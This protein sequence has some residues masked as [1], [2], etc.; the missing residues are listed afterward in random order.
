MGFASFMEDYPWIMGIVYI[1]CGPIIALFGKRWFPW[2]V[3][4]FVS[5]FTFLAVLMLF[6]VFGWMAETVG[7]II[8]IIVALGLGIFAFWFVKRTV[9]L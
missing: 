5:V 7:L 2:V 1:A 6:S 3:A 4:T 9:W 8:C